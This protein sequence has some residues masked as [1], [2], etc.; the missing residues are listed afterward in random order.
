MRQ[1]IAVRETLLV[2]GVTTFRF[3]KLLNKVK[4]R[5]V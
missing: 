4:D 2:A 5:K 1:L 3:S